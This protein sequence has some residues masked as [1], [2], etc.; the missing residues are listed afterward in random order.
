MPNLVVRHNNPTQ[1]GSSQGRSNYSPGAYAPALEQ[2][3]ISEFVNLLHRHKVLIGAIVAIVT[4][5]S[6]F[7]QLTRPT[8]Y[9]STASVQVELID[10][11]G[12]NQAEI[13]AKNNQRI[14][15][16]IKLHRSRAAAERVVRDLDLY[17][18]GDFKLDAGALEGTKRQKVWK[19]TD[20][21]LNMVEIAS[22]E[23]S[24]LV[25][26]T[27]RSRS[28]EMAALIANQYPTSV[29]KLRTR[30]IRERL[31]E[32]T[33]TL[34]KKQAELETKA[35]EA[36]RAV[37]DYRIAHGMLPGTATIEDLQQINRVATEA[38]SASAQSAAASARS[39]GIARAAQMTSTAGASN[40][41]TQALERQ[42]AE[43]A[44][45]VA[46]KSQTFGSAH[47][48]MMRL[49]AALSQVRQDLN[50][51]RAQAAAD[52]ASVAGAQ[53]AQMA[54]IARSDAA[55]AASRAGLLR[56]QLNGLTSKAYR[57]IQ[58]T[59]ELEGL[60]RDADQ[61]VR[62]YNQITER[63]ADISA[64]N[65]LEGVNSTV[66]SP[67]AI[68]NQAV[69]P[70]P[71]KMT[72][73]ALLGSMILGFLAAFA[74]DL[75][76]NKL[77]TSAQIRKLY[78]LPT[79]GML[80]LIEEN[81]GDKIE[82]SP[83]IRNPQSLFAEVARAAYF[84]VNAL[85][86]SNEAQTVLVTSPLPG[87][88]KSV[89]SVTL[90]AAAMAAGKRVAVLD[91]D[92]RKTGLIQHLKRAGTPD[93]ID[94]LR[95]HV[96]LNKV[97]P[98]MLSSPNAPESLG[99]EPEID[100]RKIALISATKP[101]AEPA[102]LLGSRALQTLLGDLRTKFDF[103]VI[104]A[105]ATLAVKDARTMCSFADETVVVARWGKTTIG[106]MNATIEMLGSDRV[107]GIIYDQVDYEKH[108][109]GR[110]GD[111]IQYYSETASYYDGPFPGR[112]GLS[113]R[114]RSLF[115]RRPR[116]ASRY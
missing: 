58:D 61:A 42:E 116:V 26:I 80:P 65:P 18:R 98:P 43:L 110:Y 107:A 17:N 45:D 70:Q 4:L 52:A 95:G 63:L 3:G 54:Q 64:R 33:T 34:T 92:L 114:I 109:R 53:S 35:E 88:G 16:E 31:A 74:L 51:A 72:A 56:S 79:F 60:T 76:D 38:I 25:E 1:L 40:A 32:L 14:A 89:V 36:S 28:P 20:Q 19:S 99:T 11:E 57:N 62:A 75:F 108:A 100:S 5:S 78:G 39:A 27:V 86:P 113:Q 67:A 96:D 85:V 10:E 81:F 71:M 55:G 97:A 69:S 7:W 15:N 115:R 106:Q 83:V 73:L 103:I 48:E 101:V 91:L 87:D 13:M 37:S 22:S 24:D 112:V 8:L 93:L 30:K 94:I 50:R 46:S 12:V 44:S 23:G 59:V 68:N 111:A 47:P 49:T 2:S 102:V 29:Q 21:L 9:S 41:S 66:V 104:N 82:E 77:R 84:D 6:L 105:P 90:A